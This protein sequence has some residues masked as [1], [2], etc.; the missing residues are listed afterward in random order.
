MFPHFFVSSFIF[1]LFLLLLYQGFNLYSRVSFLFS[2]YNTL[3]KPCPKQKTL[4]FSNSFSFTAQTIFLAKLL[5]L[6]WTSSISLAVP[7]F[8]LH[9]FL[10]GG[11]ESWFFCSVTNCQHLSFTVKHG[12]VR[13]RAGGV[14]KHSGCACF[15]DMWE[16]LQ[17]IKWVH[18]LYIHS[19]VKHIYLFLL[20][21]YLL[22]FND[23]MKSLTVSLSFANV[24][25]H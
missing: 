1:S 7:F 9:C 2:C 22:Q 19:T 14:C 16:L 17:L 13:G 24:V 4:L 25:G 20:I 5:Q 3:N 10:S 8:L 12:Q 11:R 6:F 15:M 18:C 21:P 23:D